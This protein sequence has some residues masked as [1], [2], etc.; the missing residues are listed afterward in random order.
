MPFHYGKA[1]SSLQANVNGNFPDGGAA[2]GNYLDRTCKVG[3]YKPNGYG[4][5]DMHGNVDEWCS[6]H[7]AAEYYKNS[8]KKDPKGPAKGSF[9]VNRGGGWSSPAGLCR[10]ASRWWDKPT[11]RHFCNGF[12]VVCVSTGK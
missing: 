2:K 12:R 9:R 3:S 10:S 5:Y 11:A 8:P 7:Y 4:L 6:D 1:F